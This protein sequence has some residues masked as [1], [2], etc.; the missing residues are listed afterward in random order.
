MEVVQFNVVM[1]GN[2]SVGKTSFVRRFHGGEFSSDYSSTIGE[3]CDQTWT[4]SSSEMC[5]LISCALHPGVD[6]CV[7]NIVFHDRVVK[8]QIWD[9]AGQERYDIANRADKIQKRFVDVC[10]L[11]KILFLKVSQHHHT[12]VSQGRWPFSHVWSHI[13]EEF[14]FCARLDFSNSGS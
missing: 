5:W 9:T 4:F 3:S 2:S 7:Q 10:I 11:T 1:V 12:S 14:Y 8:L 13:I 6:T